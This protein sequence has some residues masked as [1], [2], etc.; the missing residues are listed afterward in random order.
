MHLSIAQPNQYKW[1]VTS[2]LT[3]PAAVKAG[4]RHGKEL[5][6]LRDRAVDH[7]I[8]KV[9]VFTKTAIPYGKATLHRRFLKRC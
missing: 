6:D 9:T 1:H 2:A 5:S 7:S 8:W 3:R 4:T